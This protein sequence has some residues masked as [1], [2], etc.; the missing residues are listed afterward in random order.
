MWQFIAGRNAVAGWDLAAAD[1]GF[2]RALAADPGFSRA[3]L[4]LAQVRVWR[5]QPAVTWRAAAAQAVAGAARLGAR[6][7]A[8]AGLVAA[9]SRGEYGTACPR[10]LELTRTWPGE[11]PVWYGAATCLGRDTGVERDPASPTGWRFRSS[12][13]QAQR[14]WRQ[15]F[16]LLPAIYRDYRAGGLRGPGWLLWTQPGRGRSGSAIPPDTGLFGSRPTWQGDTL[17]F[18]PRRALE[19]SSGQAGLGGSTTEAVTQQR[20]AFYDLATEWASTD[21]QSLEAREAVALALWSLGN[22]SAIDSIRATRAYARSPADRARLGV[23]EALMRILRGAEDT[24]ELSEA[25]IVTDSVLAMNSDLPGVDPLDFATAAALTGR[26][27][28]AARFIRRASPRYAWRLPPALTADALAFLV[29]AALGGPTDS[30]V[31]LERRVAEGIATGVDAGRR[32]AEQGEWLG[33]PLALAPFELGLPSI[34]RLVG[35]GDYLI[36]A[37]AAQAKGDTTTARRLLRR[38]AASRSGMPASDMMFEALLPEARLLAAM[39]DAAAA[40]GRL[41]PTLATLRRVS[42]PGVSDPVG[43][44]LLVRAMALRADLA[45]AM[46]DSANAR[47]WGRA[48]AVLWS[49]S[50]PFLA[51]VVERARRASRGTTP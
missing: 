20:L 48:V 23:S 35:T 4:W 26:A 21:P 29:F 32:A 12:Y 15:A 13:H 3:A 44:G 46:R 45:M 39:G 16:A 22:A 25:R 43:A 19:F 50:D 34:A 40:V 47:R 49:S 1:S 28:L 7:I 18:L 11:F 31:E 37:S 24:A 42:L 6:D 41:D 2:A 9:M 33:R 51:P 10:W 8:L 5:G 36:D 38:A 27:K 30:L 17:A 14:A